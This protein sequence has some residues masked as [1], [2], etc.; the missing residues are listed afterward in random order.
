M[1]L[2][3][4]KLGVE[5]GT[6]Q[7]A[8]AEDV[9]V[10]HP[11]V[12]VVATGGVPDN[13]G[14]KEAVTVWDVLSGE[15]EVGGK[16]LVYDDNG[17]HA[18]PSCAEYLATAGKQ[19]EIV[20]PDRAVATDMRAL[21]RPV[22]LRNLYRLGVEMA[23]DLRLEA[24]ERVD[25]GE[26]KLRNEYSGEVVQG[27]VKFLVCWHEGRYILCFCC[28]FVLP[29]SNFLGL[30]TTVDGVFLKFSGVE[31]VTKKLRP[32]LSRALRPT[33]SWKPD[34]PRQIQNS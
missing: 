18:G 19:V 3:V 10:E 32:L 16:V 30:L 23:V 8:T 27:M 11:H 5:V 21:N 31:S 25:G 12:V 9:L 4:S 33:P 26:V 6:G 17:C 7:L 22:Y 2:K 34:L 29:V 1:Y 13:L 24:A 20:T 14:L 28:V 15:E